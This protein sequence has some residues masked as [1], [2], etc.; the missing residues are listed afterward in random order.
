MIRLLLLVAVLVVAISLAARTLRPRPALEAGPT[1][2]APAHVQKGGVTHVLVRRVAPSSGRI[3]EERPVE[4]I[5][6][7]A[8]DYDQRFLAAMAAARA[9]A[10]LY[11]SEED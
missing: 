4:T 7:D 10:A 5:H 11:A 3:L 1:S 9:R 6:A 2:W 8:P